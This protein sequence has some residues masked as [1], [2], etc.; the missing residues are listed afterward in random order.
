MALPGADDR[1]VSHRDA[2][3]KAK[4]T[5]PLLRWSDLSVAERALIVGDLA[6][7]CQAGATPDRSVF[8]AVIH[9]WGVM[10]PHPQ[11]R[12]SYEDFPWSE[13]PVAFE[14]RQWYS[15]GVCEC[16]VINR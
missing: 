3:R 15:C 1:I 11:E 10:C 4:G 16:I 2:F 6:G 9:S 5:G 13:L 14:E 7:R 12:R 8:L